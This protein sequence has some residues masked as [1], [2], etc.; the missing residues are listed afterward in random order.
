MYIMYYNTAYLVK[1]E[2]KNYFVEN[3]SFNIIKSAIT[4]AHNV[5]YVLM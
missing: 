5:I 4:L 3:Q 1:I 2:N